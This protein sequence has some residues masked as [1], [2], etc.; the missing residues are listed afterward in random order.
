MTPLVF[1]DTETTSNKP[2][3]RLVQLA[4]KRSSDG[5]IWNGLYKP[6]V[7][8][9]FEAMAVHHITEK[10]VSFLPPFA[11]ING[12][13]T[14]ESWIEGAIV[15]AHNAPFD[16]GIMANEGVVIGKW[17]D[18]L[19]VARRLW[20]DWESHKLQYIRYRLG[21][22]IEAGNAHDALADVLVLEQVFKDMIIEMNARR[23]EDPASMP[24]TGNL[25][26]MIKWSR[27]P[28]L[29]HAFAFG[30]FKGQT[31]E[32]VARLEPKY[33]QWILTTDFDEDTKYTARHWLAAKRST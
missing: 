22:E 16:I 15:V 10:I 21:I 9:S 17:I 1:L 25:S 7:P 18:T 27:E 19:K 24:D 31:F 8:I 3:A 13:K 20:P 32:E 30:K 6:P 26:L 28:S 23:T 14:V 5:C 11:D 4:M 33:L 12:S 2:D 29:L